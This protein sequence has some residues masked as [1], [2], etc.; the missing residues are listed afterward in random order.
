MF[1]ENSTYRCIYLSSSIPGKTLT[2]FVV[3]KWFS[4]DLAVRDRSAKNFQPRPIPSSPAVFSSFPKLKVAWSSPSEKSADGGRHR[5]NGRPPRTATLQLASYRIKNQTNARAKVGV[6]I[7]AQA[8]AE[9][10]KCYFTLF[11]CWAV[12][13]P[14][15][16]PHLFTRL[17]DLA[18][19]TLSTTDRL[20]TLSAL[21]AFLSFRSLSLSP[22]PSFSLTLV[23]AEHVYTHRRI[24]VLHVHTID[25]SPS[26]STLFLLSAATPVTVNN[27]VNSLR[28]YATDLQA[29]N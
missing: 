2:S 18:P 22:F 3:S 28:G 15:Q 19:S 27:C 1:F 8:S 25:S 14:L 17:S 6:P 13:N 9:Y 23:R 4:I 5:A 29:E 7:R 24:R 11:G 10:W 26:I 16:L 12:S 20:S 21:P